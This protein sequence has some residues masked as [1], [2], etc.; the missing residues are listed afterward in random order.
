MWRLYSN[1]MAGCVAG[2]VDFGLYLM[3][4][5][6]VYFDLSGLAYSTSTTLGTENTHFYRTRYQYDN[7]GAVKR[8]QT[9]LGTVTRTERDGLGRVTSE[10][11]GTDDTPTSGNWSPSNTGGTR[12]AQA[13]P[14]GTILV[15][16][17]RGTRT[18]VTEWDGT[19]TGGTT[20]ARAA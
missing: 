12:L 11:V 8:V 6:D 13:P 17:I 10:W 19:K 1:L 15:A 5:S 14:Q 16:P 3:D 4:P 2:I 9:P 18:G 20:R 7:H